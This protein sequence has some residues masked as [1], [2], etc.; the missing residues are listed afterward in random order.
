MPFCSDAQEIRQASYEA[1]TNF[2]KLPSS[3]ADVIEDGTPRMRRILR[4]LSLLLLPLALLSTQ[5]RAGVQLTVDGVA[6]PL[7][8][9][10]I[11]GV[12]L[13]QYATRE[14]SDAQLRRLYERAPAQVKSSLE[15]YG[16]YDATV[17]GDL[18][19]IGKNW[20]VTLHVKP[21]EP[22]KI[23]AVDV[24]LDKTAA[25]IAPIRRAQRAIERLQGATLNDAAYENA[26]D[27][28]SAQL[29]AN[30][31][32]DARLLTHRVEVNRG[33]RRAVIKLAWKAGPR[34]RY[35][36]VAFEGSQFNPGFL[37]RYVPF[38]SGDYFSQEQLLALQQA[39]N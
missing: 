17:T 16:Y 37:D 25:G 1:N 29:T 21:G 13:S 38:K 7:K 3:S 28:L 8:A 36:K 30:G 26:R 10:V 6:D 20:Q 14:V 4:R 23:T 34:Y 12:E 33:D 31:F 24:Q 9:A 35:G 11:S 27:A 19:Q 15:P 32:L 22:V 2:G 39:L 5:A 18:Q